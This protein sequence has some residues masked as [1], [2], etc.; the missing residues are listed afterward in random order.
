MTT[1][2]ELPNVFESNM[3]FEADRPVGEGVTNRQNWIDFCLNSPTISGMF[4]RI[5]IAVLLAI[6]AT[7]VAS[8]GVIFS[9]MGETEISA[10][11]YLSCCM[12]AAASDHD[13]QSGDVEASP[14]Q[15][16]TIAPVPVRSSTSG[17]APL[18]NSTDVYVRA[19]CHETIK[20]GNDR[21][22]RSPY[23]RG[24]LKPV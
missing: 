23:L 19:R 11:R 4:P 9:G 3:R 18:L 13:N 22:P 21:L 14:G 7:H 17:H 15:K 2:S 5:L 20:L 1:K 12:S 16:G 10:E 24:D 8:A 6:G